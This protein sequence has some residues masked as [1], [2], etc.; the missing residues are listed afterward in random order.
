MKKAMGKKGKKTVM[1]LAAAILI[2]AAGVCLYGYFS[3]SAGYTGQDYTI[4]EV[5]LSVMPADTD[6]LAQQ[7][8]NN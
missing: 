6:E 7:L 3:S 4:P 8:Q 2:A 5:D 1:I